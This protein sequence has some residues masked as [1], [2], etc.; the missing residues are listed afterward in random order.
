MMPT[1]TLI[2]SC[3]NSPTEEHKVAK[4]TICKKI[5]KHSCVDLTISE[6]RTINGK[7]GLTWNCSSCVVLGTD[8]QALQQ[9]IVELKNEI[10]EL[11]RTANQNISSTIDN[12]QFEEILQEINERE[13]RKCNVV[14]FGISEQQNLGNQTRAE[15]D[16][17][18]VT[19]IFQAISVAMPGN[20]NIKAIRIGKFDESKNFPRPVKVT[21]SDESTV[22]EIIHKARNLKSTA[23]YKN[24][25]ISLDRTPRQI[26]LYRTV[27]RQ[28]N[29]RIAAGETNLRIKYIRG[30]PKVVT[31]N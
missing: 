22:H 27:K 24:I 1:A 15:Q 28:L 4:C 11:K 6:V 20:E 19:N 3:C 8:M 25:N 12:N 5:F 2:C 16:K 23:N 7:K 17:Q 26:E 18:L 31:L 21:V 13:K 10:V 9:A 30:V 29:E 14:I